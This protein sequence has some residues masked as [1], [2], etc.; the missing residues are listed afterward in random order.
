M[1]NRM[2]VEGM[3]WVLRTGAPW[4]DLPERFGRWHT[5]YQRFRRWTVKGVMV[6]VFALYIGRNPKTVM[7]DGSFAMLH[8]H[9]AGAM[10]NGMDPTESRRAQKIGR[11]SGGLSTKLI[12]VVDGDGRALRVTLTPGNRHEGPLLLE[13]IDGIA[14]GEV[15]ADKAYGSNAN[16]KF[17]ADRGIAATIPSRSHVIKPAAYDAEKYRTR[18]LVENLFADIKHFRGVA[19][20]YCKTASSF[21][22]FVNMA[23]WIV[24]SRPT[25]RSLN[26]C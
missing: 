1:N 23:V 12:A 9:G 13:A 16:R 26:P 15:I 7:I 14:A 3:V 25:R 10:R 17:L 18:H 6:K 19:T 20:R 5:V 8:Q 21:E 22:S 4:R 2:S 11:S 24:N